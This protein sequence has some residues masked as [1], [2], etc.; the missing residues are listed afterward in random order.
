MSQIQIFIPI[1]DVL[2]I[3][4]AMIDIFKQVQIKRNDGIVGC[5]NKIKLGQMSIF[6][7]GSSFCLIA[8]GKALGYTQFHKSQSMTYSYRKVLIM[9]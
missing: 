4:F 1:T 9:F 5:H 6:F 2:F 7:V 3:I 8:Y